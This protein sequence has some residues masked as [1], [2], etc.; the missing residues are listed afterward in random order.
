MVEACEDYAIFMLDPEGR[1]ATWNAGAERIKG[2]R[3]EEIIGQHFSRFYPQEAI[4][5]GWPDE[6]LEAGRS[7]GPVRGRG[8]AGPQGRL[9]LL[10]QRR[11]HRP[12]RQAGELRGFAKVTRDMTE[13]R[14]AEERLRQ[15]NA[16]LEEQVRRRTAES[17]RASG[18][19]C[20]RHPHQHRR[21]RDRHR[22]GGASQLPEPGG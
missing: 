14:Q 3:A 7:R 13:R 9:P 19:G 22:P 18:S 11:H 1:V 21:C 17:A 5:R 15:A 20:G 2:Y 6:E 16:G 8:L 4:E 10:G 12:A